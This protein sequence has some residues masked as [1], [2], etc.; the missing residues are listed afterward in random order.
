[1]LAVQNS[2]LDVVTPELR[3]VIVDF[4]KEKSLLYIRFYYDGDP[5]EKHLTLWESAI[6]K[7]K[8]IFNPNC[9]LDAAIERIDYPNNMPF[10]GRYAYARKE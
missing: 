8:A 10:R 7:S 3:T 6:Y 1:M 2:L 9:I 4:D 5:S